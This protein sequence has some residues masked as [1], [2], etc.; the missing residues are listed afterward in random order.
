MAPPPSAALLEN[1]MNVALRKGNDAAVQLF[2]DLYPNHF[3]PHLTTYLP[4]AVRCG[5][6]DAVKF[7]IA[8]GAELG[9][10]EKEDVIACVVGSRGGRQVLM[11]LE[12]LGL[13]IDEEVW[14]VLDRMGYT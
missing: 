1:P 9:E 3:T 5:A 14:E 11:L 12:E 13:A 2:L 8:R 6:F 10:V 4:I 7:L